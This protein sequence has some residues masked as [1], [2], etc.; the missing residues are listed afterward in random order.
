MPP[1][2]WVTEA[3]VELYG[4]RPGQDLELPLAGQM[5]PFT[6]VGVWR[7]YARQFGGDR[8]RTEDYEAAHRRHRRS[9]TPRCG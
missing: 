8:I 6:V 7:D 4:V 2:V 1:P 3:M 9:R 5:E